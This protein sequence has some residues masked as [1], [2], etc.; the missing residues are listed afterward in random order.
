MPQA[1][2]QARCPY[3]F[4]QHA[5]MQAITQ[6]RQASNILND[7]DWDEALEFCDS[8]I[9][10]AMQ[11]LRREGIAPPDI[12]VD[13]QD[14]NSRVVGTLEA[15]WSDLKVGIAI[16]KE[17][18]SSIRSVGW[19]LLELSDLVTNPSCVLRAAGCGRVV[20]S[21][22]KCYQQTNKDLVSHAKLRTDQQPP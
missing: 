10:G 2:A 19:E 21:E 5:D 7:P 3:N 17:E 4:T 22:V 13:V 18:A 20:G 15:A 1:S 16:S 11:L 8:G 9:A 14:A 6:A 12:G